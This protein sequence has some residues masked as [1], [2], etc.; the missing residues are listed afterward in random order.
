M[1]AGKKLRQ[2]T[3]K[4]EGELDVRVLKVI[5]PVND[6]FIA[7]VNYHNYRLLPWLF[8]YGD[9]VAHEL[10]KMVREIAVQ[11]KDCSFF[12]KDRMQVIALL[13]EFKPA[14]NA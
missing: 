5:K 12:E 1:T 13:H 14:C 2:C 10:Y 11:M 3:P 6:P 4:Q 9:E 7:V 8:G